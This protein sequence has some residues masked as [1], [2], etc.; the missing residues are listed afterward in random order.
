[1]IFKKR[2]T[3]KFDKQRTEKGMRKHVK[4]KLV[5]RQEFY[6]N[7]SKR[8]KREKEDALKMRREL[9]KEFTIRHPPSNLTTKNQ[10]L[11]P[12]TLL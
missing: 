7:E 8:I 1:M 4:K 2:R 3:S 5:V 12:E 9:Q 6:H 10:W 11:L